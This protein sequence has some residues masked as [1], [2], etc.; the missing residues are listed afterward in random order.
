M[1]WSS[2]VPFRD[3][4]YFH[5][6]LIAGKWYVN[7]LHVHAD[8]RGRMWCGSAAGSRGSRVKDDRTVQ[9]AG[10]IPEPKEPQA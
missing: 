8:S 10:P 3:G 9:W 2:D 1:T 6:Q 4:W 5:R 7:V